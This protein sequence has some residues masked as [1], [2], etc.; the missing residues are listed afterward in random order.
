VFAGRVRDRIAGSFGEDSVFIDV[1]NIPFGKDFRVHIHEVL[2]KADAVLVVIGPKWLGGDRRGRARIQ[3][4]TDPVR[5]EVET[6]LSK[7]IPTI[8]ILVGRTNMPKPEQLPESLRSFS[9]VNAAPVDTGRDFHRDVDRVIAT[10][11]A[12]LGQPAEAIRRHA[13]DLERT[14]QEAERTNAYGTEVASDAPALPA[15]SP[16]SHS[17]S[18]EA[19]QLVTEP[20]P[21]LRG[22]RPRIAV[23]GVF[24]VTLAG[25]IVYWLV[26]NPSVPVPQ[27]ER[28]L[29]QST[30]VTPPPAQ[31]PQAPPAKAG[32]QTPVAA[33]P[34]QVPKAPPANAGAQTSVTT[35]PA[36]TPQVPPAKDEPQKPAE[37]HI[38]SPEQAV[39]L[40]YSPWTKFCLNGQDVS[41]KQPCFIG[42]DASAQSGATVVTAAIVQSEGQKNLL[43]VVLPLGMQLIYGTRVIVDQSTPIVAPY[44]I[45]S[46]HGCTADYE[47]TPDMI[48]KMK[49]GQSLV[50]QAIN[51]TG[52]PLSLMLPLADF[53]QAYEGAPTA[54]N[55]VE[56]RQ[57]AALLPLAADSAAHAQGQIVFSPWT[58]FCLK[59]QEANAKLVCFTG[60]DASIESGKPVFAA[61]LIEPEGD[62]KKILRI[63]LPLGMQLDHGTRVIIDQNQPLTVPYVV[64][65]TNGCLADYD[66]T[67]DLIPK[68][69]NGQ[70]LVIRAINSTGQPISQ[71]LPLQDFAKAYDG[72]PTN[73]TAS[74]EQQK[75]P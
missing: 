8:P 40:I 64:C 73:P 17:E 57:Q 26:T 58:K 13:Q 2:L 1:D 30:P 27:A 7:G 70:S 47:A 61:V 71:V 54:P 23:A 60:K 72:P 46:A 32:A 66:A 33:P 5:I 65:F 15:S 49:T 19:R 75:K 41:A 51:S 29:V 12:I 3:D 44:G 69:K 4:D 31:I 34:A 63:T 36:Q 38:S 50:V 28:N 59:G 45:C 48:H 22:L 6:A 56:A 25:G 9:Y 74:K 16:Y 68:L 21:G 55:A 62:P 35:P 24:A 52:Q 18:S 14:R 11:G 37:A 10:L 43:R 39:Q 42:K 20:Q 67:S 53:S